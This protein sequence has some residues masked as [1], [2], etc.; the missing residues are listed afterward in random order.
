MAPIVGPT[1]QA[2]HVAALGLPAT[3]VRPLP[4]GH[5][6]ARFAPVRPLEVKPGLQVQVLLEPVALEPTAEHAEQ[7]SAAPVWPFV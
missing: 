1:T 7:V 6:H 4:A 3:V 2:E 5:V